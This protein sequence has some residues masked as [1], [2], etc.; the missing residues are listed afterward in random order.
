MPYNSKIFF[1]VLILTVM[2]TDCAILLMYHDLMVYI[3]NTTS[4]SFIKQISWLFG[5][6]N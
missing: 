2:M 5:L 3:R 6:M 1:G 4:L